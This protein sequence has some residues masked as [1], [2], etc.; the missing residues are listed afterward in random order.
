MEEQQDEPEE[1]IE[2]PKIKMIEPDLNL[3]EECV[4]Y[5]G[6][7]ITSAIN[8]TEIEDGFMDS[9]ESFCARNNAKLYVVPIK[10]LNPS[11]M[12]MNK[13]VSWPDRVDQYILRRT[14]KWKEQFK[15]IGDCNIQATAQN[16]LS[17]IDTLCE[18]MTTIVGHPV[19]QMKTVAVNHGLDPI[20]LHSTGSVSK[21]NKY[22]ASKAGYRAS[23]HHCNSAVYIELDR[24]NSN[25][26]IRQLCA[27]STG[28]FYDLDTYYSPDGSIRHDSVSAVVLGD[29]HV[30]F[31]DPEVRSATFGDGGLV[32]L[33]DPEIL[34][35]HDV[36]DF[37]AR[38]HHEMKKFTNM[39]ERYHMKQ[40]NV[41]DELLQTCEHL[42][43]TTYGR[44]SL[45]VSSNHHSHL[46]KWLE[47][48]DPKLDP[49]NAI[50]YHKLM[51][52]VLEHIKHNGS[53]PDPFRLYFENFNQSKGLPAEVVFLDD[54]NYYIN[55]VCVSMH[56]DLGP[57]GSRGSRMNL[58]KIGERSV[59]GHS[60][61]PGIQGGC[62]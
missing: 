61:S 3:E 56:G 12:N 14:L 51:Y 41:E 37:H 39:F 4:G 27:D 43:S 25:F 26:H 48:A 21:K 38:S 36:L 50:I 24:D 10:Y 29:E 33:L 60:H 30:V 6:I 46:L 40:D 54:D 22:S 2:S 53:I 62:W 45:V 16:P 18:G 5:E 8:D 17:S 9:L 13:Q 15:I 34:V 58:S 11:A 19:L 55:D 28:G 49:T 35:R 52:C 42:V 23:F 59:I 31:M 32:D 57:N 20:I 44:R 7:V 47:T 1:K